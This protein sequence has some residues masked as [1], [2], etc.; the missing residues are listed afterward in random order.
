MLNFKT[1]TIVFISLFILLLFPIYFFLNQVYKTSDRAE[2]LLEF[3]YKIEALPTND[4]I[5]EYISWLDINDLYFF[6]SELYK[7]HDKDNDNQFQSL[8]E[9]DN[10]IKNLEIIIDE[11]KR[12]LRIIFEIK[13]LESISSIRKIVSQAIIKRTQEIISKRNDIDFILESLEKK[14]Y[15]CESMLEDLEDI[16]ETFTNEQKKSTIYIDLLSASKEC[17]I[18]VSENNT[19]QDRISE[20][21]SSVFENEIF[22]NNLYSSITRKNSYDFLGLENY[23]FYV[24]TPIIA[25]FFSFLLT[26]AIILISFFWKL[27]EA[28]D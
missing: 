7:I 24:L 4:I 14:N 18:S 26:F 17:Q 25:I 3:I 20:M 28:L 9:Y 23:N 12:I 6:E 2:Y 16:K 10:S 5:N 8:S 19:L 27:K 11:P 1:A 21:N 15:A 13:D 22:R